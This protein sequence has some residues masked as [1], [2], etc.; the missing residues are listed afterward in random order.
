MLN[1]SKWSTHSNLSEKLA[2]TELPIA[3]GKIPCFFEKVSTLHWQLNTGSVPKDF[4]IDK[5]L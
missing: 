4:Q 2:N 5:D 1:S 3:G